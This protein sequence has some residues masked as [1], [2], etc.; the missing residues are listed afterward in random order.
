MLAD[1]AM[2]SDAWTYVAQEYQYAS[3]WITVERPPG[4]FCLQ[5]KITSSLDI[6]LTCY[7]TEDSAFHV[8]APMPLY[9]FRSGCTSV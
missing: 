3:W 1:D 8:R 2:M 4:V 9:V 6:F 5:K 7:T